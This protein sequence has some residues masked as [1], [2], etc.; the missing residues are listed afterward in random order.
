MMSNDYEKIFKD[1]GILYG[2]WEGVTLHYELKLYTHFGCF[3]LMIHW[4]TD[5][6]M[7]SPLS[8]LLPFTSSFPEI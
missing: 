1:R 7:V 3:L 2:S 5:A 4:R 8:N 6:W